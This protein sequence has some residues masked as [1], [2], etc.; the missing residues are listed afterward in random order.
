MFKISNKGISATIGLVII[1]TVAVLATGGILAW[2]NGWFTKLIGQKQTACTTEAKVCPDGSAVGRTGPNCEF[3]PCPSEASCEGGECPIAKTDETANWKTYINSE[4]GFEIKYPINWKLGEEVSTDVISTIWWDSPQTVPTTPERRFIQVGAMDFLEGYS[5]SQILLSEQ[6]DCENVTMGSI[7][8][9][10]LEEK[11]ISKQ[12]I[13]Y[14]VSKNNKIYFLRLDI[15]GGRQKEGYYLPKSE[16]QDE[17]N[18][19][20][21]M[22]S[23]FKFTK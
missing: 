13:V 1:I 6:K 9:C 2:Q 5:I 20:N 12:S 16:I 19:F 14:A 21:Q 15:E 23:T 3:A 22:L 7:K 17:L 11:F 4:Y 18:I 8:F 10:K